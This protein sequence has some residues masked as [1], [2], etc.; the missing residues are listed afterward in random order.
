MLDFK[1]LLVCSLVCFLPVIPYKDDWP[2]LDGILKTISNF[3][4][5]STSILLCLYRNK[6]KDFLIKYFEKHLS[7]SQLTADSETI[8]DPQKLANV[9]NN[10]FVNVSTQFLLR[11]HKQKSHPLIT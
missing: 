6:T 2:N 8:H 4:L 5:L 10:F 3:M 9:F 1:F 7:I 11:Y